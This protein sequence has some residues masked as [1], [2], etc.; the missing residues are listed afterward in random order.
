MTPIKHSACNDVLRAPAGDENCADLHIY[1][2]DEVVASFWKPDEDELAA[3]VRGGS[4]FMQVQGRTH[5]PLGLAVVPPEPEHLRQIVNAEEAS[6][7][8][9]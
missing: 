4:V 7:R 2:T 5:P 8:G 1:R 9:D 3:L 6:L